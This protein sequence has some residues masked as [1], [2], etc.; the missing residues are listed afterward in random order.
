MTFTPFR[1]RRIAIA[2]SVLLSSFLL[3]PAEANV[4]LSNTVLGS[5]VTTQDSNC[6][7]LVM[8][9]SSIA[10]NAGTTVD[11]IFTL[12]L[13]ANP[14]ADQALIGGQSGAVNM[15][16]DGG[17]SFKR[18]GLDYGNGTAEFYLQNNAALI[19]GTKY[20][21]AVENTGSKER[22]WLNGVA[23]T[24]NSG[25]NA[26]QYLYDTKPLGTAHNIT[27]I[28]NFY[29]SAHG[30]FQ[31]TISYVRIDSALVYPILSDTV[32][33]TST[34][35]NTGNTL[36]LMLPSTNIPTYSLITSASYSNPNVTFAGTNNFAVGDSVTVKTASAPSGFAKT[37]VSVI[38]ATSTS[39]TLNYG[40]SP[41]TFTG[42]GSA[43]STA[44]TKDEIGNTAISWYDGICTSANGAPGIVVTIIAALGIS[45]GGNTAIYRTATTLQVP[46]S[47]AGKITFYQ[48][49]KAIAGCK[50]VYSAIG[51]ATCI[52]RPTQHGYT[53][54]TA[55]LVPT[56]N[57]LVTTLPGSLKVFVITRT[58]TR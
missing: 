45:G 2:A 10:P 1:L 47:V 43:V 28:G 53:N 35:S 55:V 22:M 56:N 8:P 16:I 52:W 5:T 57:N 37:N 32:T 17:Q 7:W 3:S 13:T 12:A 6:G 21:I 18:I 34:L 11:I 15:L 44:I 20:H 9:S 54:L 27:Q 25:S 38:A 41:G 4:L 46:M 30:G 50:N 40:S 51:T 33:M 24:V 26:P 19:P 58:S 29:G 31:G 49:G 23:M 42:L 14:A 36:F 48:Q 39:F